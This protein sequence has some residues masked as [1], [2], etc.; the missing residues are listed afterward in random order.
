MTRHSSYGSTS[1]GM[2]SSTSTFAFGFPPPLS[3]DQ[4]SNAS[5]KKPPV[6]APSPLR[7]KQA[8][9]QARP[10]SLKQGSKATSPESQLLDQWS[11][12]LQ[13]YELVLDSLASTSLDSN[14]KEEI[15]HVDQWYRYLSEAE[16]TA[17]MYALLQHSTPLQI[18]FFVTVLQQ[19][20]NQDPVS[21]L[22]SPVYAEYDTPRKDTTTPIP[23]TRRDI[24]NSSRKQS[25]K[26]KNRH[27]FAF[28]EV[29][30][31]SPLPHSSY[32]SFTEADG[33]LGSA[34]SSS[35]SSDSRR[36]SDDL[37][38]S[39]NTPQFPTTANGWPHR[40]TNTGLRTGNQDTSSSF[41]RHSMARP[42]SA[43]ISQWSLG[44][45]PP[46][47][48]PNASGI[49]DGNHHPSTATLLSQ[50]I[51][52]MTP[53]KPSRMSLQL[54]SFSSPKSAHFPNSILRRPTNTLQ[55]DDSNRPPDT[56]NLVD[57]L[58]EQFSQ[59]PAFN[60]NQRSPHFRN[61][62]VDNSPSAHLR[63]HKYT[64]LFESMTWQTIILL[65]DDDLIEKGIAA[66]GA[67]RKLLKVFDQ[68]KQHCDNMNIP[69]G[70]E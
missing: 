61:G 16:R 46:S 5:T 30:E 39:P 20:G 49:S 33:L 65:T 34:S 45:P 63:L 41:Y 48:F 3:T 21:S 36:L 17:T 47:S 38:D 1:T 35:A 43:D 55:S 14:V 66:L 6:S 67:R 25:A 58:T 2:Y 26:S 37:I 53:S 64:S 8:V 69:Y 54:D 7:Q 23:L 18:R 59:W 57:P 60:H 51:P 24:M 70:P 44:L 50:G 32:T 62:A 52:H 29:Q 12:D 42:K 10:E 27:S 9:G 22:L 4:S 56:N 11:E 28:G 40:A 13:Q 68:V 15:K 19:L 31:S